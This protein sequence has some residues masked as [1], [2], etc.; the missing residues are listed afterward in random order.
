M[1]NRFFSASQASYG[2]PKER[3]CMHCKKEMSDD[4]SILWLRGFCSDACRE[5]Y[6]SGLRNER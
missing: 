6:I 1:V 5:N 3:T 2:L 4:G